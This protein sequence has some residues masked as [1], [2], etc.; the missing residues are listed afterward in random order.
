MKRGVAAF[1]VDRTGYHVHW[2]AVPAWVMDELLAREAR[3][4][5]A[6]PS[7]ERVCRG[8][9]LS[10]YQY[11]IDLERWGYRDGRLPPNGRLTRRQA[12]AL[13][14]EPHEG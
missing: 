11:R 12:Q 7:R 9:L 4:R 14:R 1:S 13:D 10:R 6:G 3:D 2:D 5:A 8:T